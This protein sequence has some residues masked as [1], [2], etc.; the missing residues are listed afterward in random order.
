MALL[1]NL[2][3][4]AR[5]PRTDYLRIG[6]LVSLCVHGAV[7]AIRPHTPD[8]PP[9]PQRPL[10]VALVNTQTKLVPHDPQIL[11]QADLSGGGDERSGFSTTPLPRTT[12]QPADEI[13][14]ADLRKRQAQLEQEQQR[15]LSQITSQQT[16]PASLTD[17]ET[18]EDS[19]DPGTDTRDQESLI[20]SAQIA[21]L[22]ERIERYN[23]Q[24]RQQFT[25]PSARTDAYAHY[26]EAWRT[27]IEQLGTDHYPDQ[28]RGRV[29]GSLQLTVYIRQD[30]TLER[31]QID[32]PSEHAILN[33][34]AQRIVQLAAPFAPLPP[35]IAN[36]ADILAI[37]RTWHFQNQQLHTQIP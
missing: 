20:L 22:K 12:E 18:L 35:V 8:A 6:L 17:Q 36:D 2:L 31:I 1:S 24:P 13:V 10:E 26:L 16:T 3:L 33:L 15:L 4:R 25:G 37:T 5:A 30:G 11:A 7:L 27:K 28:A 19:A 34:A 14:L 23:A 9:P 32:R 21:A 29:Y